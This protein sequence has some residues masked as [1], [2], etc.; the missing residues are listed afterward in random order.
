MSPALRRLWFDPS[1][2]TRIGVVVGALV[3]ATLIEVLAGASVPG[4]MPAYAL[5]GTFVLVFGAKRLGSVIQK[6]LAEIEP[7][8]LAGATEVAMAEG[9][10]DA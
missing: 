5:V 1:L 7:A 3:I 2:A 6:P 10:G 8:E 9:A 4:R